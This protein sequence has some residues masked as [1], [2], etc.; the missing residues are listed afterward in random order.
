MNYIIKQLF[1]ILSNNSYVLLTSCLMFIYMLYHI[2]LFNKYNTHN[3]NNYS[4]TKYIEH[5][6]YTNHNTFLRHLNTDT[7]NNNNSNVSLSDNIKQFEFIKNISTLI[8]YGEWTSLSIPNNTLIE[9]TGIAGFFFQQHKRSNLLPTITNTTLP[10]FDFDFILKDGEYRDNLLGGNFS[11]PLPSNFSYLLHHS[12][13]TNTSITLTYPNITMTYFFL[14][15]FDVINDNTVNQTNLTITLSPFPRRFI[16]SNHKIHIDALFTMCDVI[17]TNTFHNI[18]MNFKG[19]MSF[20]DKYSSQVLNYS[21]ILSLLGAVHMLYGFK[22]VLKINNNSQIGIN[23]DFITIFLQIIWDNIIGG[24]HLTF[25]YETQE[26]LYEFTIPSIIYFL[27]SLIIHVKILETSWKQHNAELYY[28][29]IR[30][31]KKKL[32]RFTIKLFI[33]VFIFTEGV[34]M[35]YASPLVNCLLFVS[36]WV[37]QI[38]HSARNASKPPMSNSYIITFTI[39]KLFIMCYVKAYANNIFSIKPSYGNVALVGCVMVVEVLVLN[40]QMVLGGSVVVPSCLK[41][42]P[43]DYYVKYEDVEGKGLECAICLDKFE[44]GI[45][46][47]IK[48]DDYDDNKKD[49]KKGW[50]ERLII[51]FKRKNKESAYMR[52]PCNHY[53][54]AS[55]LLKWCEE[56][57]E[58]PICRNRLPDIEE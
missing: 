48:G 52:T 46:Q 34:I 42:K 45:V 22:F 16:S 50:M 57:N 55:C 17:I 1:H 13:Q 21:I 51:R 56:K 28:N 41:K 29:D 36:T 27:F 39:C 49:K 43:F 10:S 23:V 15:Y 54:H 33:A 44:G 40:V 38:I 30:L 20:S 24:M 53:Y 37:F 18:S 19:K 47:M 3:N 26:Y 58:C 5:S 9:K 8:Y 14:K 11:L 31:F 32:L 4:Y 25:A 7:S 35:Y 6:F 12:L 2:P